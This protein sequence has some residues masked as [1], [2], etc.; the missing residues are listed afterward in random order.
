MQSL[1]LVL[2]SKPKTI[3]DMSKENIDMVLHKYI[4]RDDE[5][6]V[7]HEEF[8]NILIRNHAV[9]AGGSIL[10]AIHKYRI[11]DIDM[12]V[13]N[14]ND[15]I[16][17]I[18][19]LRIF[20]KKY[21]IGLE[22][23]KQVILDFNMRSEYAD[24]FFMENNILSRCRMM[25]FS[26][27]TPLMFDII[28]CSVSKLDVIQ[29]FDLSFC[30]VWYDGKTVSSNNVQDVLTKVGRLNKGYYK[31]IVSG[32][33]FI[34]NRIIKYT[35]VLGYK[36][37]I[38]CEHCEPIELPYKTRKQIDDLY[39]FKKFIKMLNWDSLITESLADIHK[40]NPLAIFK[41]LDKNQYPFI[42]PNNERINIES[43]YASDF[44]KLDAQN[45]IVSD[46]HILSAVQGM[47]Y[48]VLYQFHKN[49]YIVVSTREDV[50]VHA[51]SVVQTILKN[52]KH[53]QLTP[54]HVLYFIIGSAFYL[55][56]LFMSYEYKSGFNNK[57]SKKNNNDAL[58]LRFISMIRNMFPYIFNNPNPQ[59][60]EMM[61][62]EF[63][64]YFD[65]TLRDMLDL[66]RV[67]INTEY[68]KPL[69]RLIFTIDTL[70]KLLNIQ[71]EDF[72]LDG[73]KLI[74][75]V[76]SHIVSYNNI[77]GC[78][79]SIT[80]PTTQEVNSMKDTT[81][82]DIMELECV[83]IRDC[84]RKNDKT[85]IFV[86]EHEPIGIDV[87]NIIKTLSLS[88]VI[89]GC[90]TPLPGGA[91]R[92]S[93]NINFKQ[94]FIPLAG[95][96]KREYITIQCLIKILKK[97]KKYNIRIFKLGKLKTIE[98]T[99]GISDVVAYTED[100]EN[101]F[102]TNVNLISSTHCN[103]GSQIYYWDEINYVTIEE[104]GGSTCSIQ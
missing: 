4:S 99:T 10:S 28:L 75:D 57:A 102:H 48:R 63:N 44:C 2:K 3:N 56:G 49:T 87:D 94:M 7:N 58:Q 86:T 98:Y 5:F 103:P 22:N 8:I 12:Y 27:W 53:L 45:K 42:I 66:F 54:E 100:N 64:Q 82:F 25:Y 30:S 32:N 35:R 1:K 85:I 83:N 16:N 34:S 14:N 80:R 15:Y 55:S 43:T 77:T 76:L 38:I 84:I 41:V 101:I 92:W 69:K 51:I 70:V 104:Q 13:D 52:K 79:T 33:K 65:T 50:Y 73:R 6:K 88:N 81:Y 40:P 26:Q 46:Q 96:T 93:P 19:D 29:N 61:V 11:N 95:S 39:G 59:L 47:I 90:N 23:N 91:A 74:Y 89:L 21:I 71:T 24:S 31:Y 68:L 17:L 62:E 60:I 36:I 37:N 20:I 78:G 67:R 72:M 9:I 18:R 97:Y